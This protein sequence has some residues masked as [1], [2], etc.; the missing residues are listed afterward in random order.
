MLS[1]GLDSTYVLYKTLKDTKDKVWVHHIILKNNREPRWK[2]ELE[3]TQK[4]VEYCKKIRTFPYSESE[5]GFYLKG[6]V[7]WD[8]DVITFT[9]AQMVPNIYPHWGKVILVTGR[10]KEDDDVRSS[11]NQ[12]VY[13]QT[14]WEAATKQHKMHVEKE[15][16]KPIRH[17][18]KKDLLKDMPQELIDMVWYCRRGVNGSPCGHCRSCRDIQ[19]AKQELIDTRL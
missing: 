1:G 15:I 11:L 17:L 19:K 12:T 16:S 3:A 2:E 13:T 4:V 9:A 5:W 18:S 6:F 7:P 8:I 14:L 10:V